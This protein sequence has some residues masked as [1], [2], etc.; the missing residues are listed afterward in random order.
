MVT[1]PETDPERLNTVLLA[2]H[3]QAP[4]LTIRIDILTRTTVSLHRRLYL[5]DPHRPGQG[6][7]P[8]N[9]LPRFPD[10][11]HEEG[12]HPARC[13]CGIVVGRRYADDCPPL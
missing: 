13:L 8:G 1:N 12:R 11:V 4:S 5:P 7:H 10:K 2:C 6:L 3:S 9:V